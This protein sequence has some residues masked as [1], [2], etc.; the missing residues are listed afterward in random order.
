MG[1]G[2]MKTDGAGTLRAAD[3]GRDVVLAGWISRRRDH[4]GVIFV[5]LRDGSG[6]V[7][8]VLNPDESPADEDTLH[9][10]RMEFCVQVEGTVQPRPEGTVND[11][12][13]TGDVEVSATTIRVLSPADPLPFPLDGRTDIDEGKRL[14]YRYLDMRRQ[15]VAENLKARSKAIRAMREVMDETGFLEV[16]TPTLIASTP[17][18]IGRAHV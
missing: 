2:P 1:A 5:D 18:E 8:V 13:P 7:Q 12:M 14:Q 11:D 17:E 4:G 6:L 9:G 16:E 3:A 10:L 15:R